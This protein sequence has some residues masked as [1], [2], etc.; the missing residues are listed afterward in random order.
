M[1]QPHPLWRLQQFGESMLMR[2]AARHPPRLIT[3]SGS[4]LQL[5]AELRAQGLERVLI[6]TMPE[7][8]GWGTVDPL[9]KALAPAGIAATVFSDVVVEP[10]DACIE[11]AATLFGSTAV[12]A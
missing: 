3:G 12:R 6:I 1:S 11:K 5:P 10:T 8:I 9:L 7:F 4:L 2:N